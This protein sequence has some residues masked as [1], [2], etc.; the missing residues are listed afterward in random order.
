[1][2]TISVS[3]KFEAAPEALWALVA[4]FAHADRYLDGMVI[5]KMV[6]EGV[7]SDR[8]VRAGELLVV[9]RLMALDPAARSITYALVD[10]PA[11]F[12]SYESTMTVVAEGDGCRLDWVGTV[13]TGGEADEPVA[14]NMQ[15]VYLG[16]AQ[17]LGELLG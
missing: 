10:P 4:D 1:M 15:Q 11:P 3:T 2:P 5:E 7:G 14:A 6:G 9:E 17:R 8:H 16:G 12:R 13:D